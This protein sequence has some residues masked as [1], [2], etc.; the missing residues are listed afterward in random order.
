MNEERKPYEVELNEDQMKHVKDLY[1]SGNK[2]KAD[3]PKYVER[4]D[5]EEDLER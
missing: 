4:D 2:P 1:T 5:K 3:P